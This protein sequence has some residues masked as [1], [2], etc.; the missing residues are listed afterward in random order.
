VKTRYYN[1]LKNKE[2]N[3]NKRSYRWENT[4]R[5]LETPGVAGIK[6]GITNNAGPCL[7]TS[8]TI[9]N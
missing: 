8:I 5:M 7:A 1:V 4:H 3:G 6:T 2:L 9:D